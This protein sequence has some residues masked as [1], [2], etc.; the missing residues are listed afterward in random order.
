MTTY[1][2]HKWAVACMSTEADEPIYK[3]L[4]SWYGG[5]A[6]SDSWKLSSGIEKIEDNG[7][8]YSIHNCSGSIYKCG[9]ENYGTSIYTQSVFMTWVNQALEN[10]NY[11]ISLL[12]NIKDIGMEIK[13]AN[14]P[15]NLPEPTSI[16][17][18]IDSIG[19]TPSELDW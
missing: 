17:T 19:S 11:S 3:I 15:V 9:K 18:T 7:D 12:D 14:V 10:G 5:F 8:Y 6:G 4:S 1:N 13:K 16:S 2:P